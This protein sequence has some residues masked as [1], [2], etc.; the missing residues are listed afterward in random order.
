MDDHKMSSKA[1][2][3]TKFIFPKGIERKGDC[4][5]NWLWQAYKGD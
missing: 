1:V 3:A 5:E 4:S 2:V